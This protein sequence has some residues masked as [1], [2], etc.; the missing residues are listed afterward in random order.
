MG[1]GPFTLVIDAPD[2]QAFQDGLRAPLFNSTLMLMAGSKGKTLAPLISTE[3]Q[4][5]NWVLHLISL[6]WL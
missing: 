1:Q 4:S 5:L 3:P 6:R 2:K